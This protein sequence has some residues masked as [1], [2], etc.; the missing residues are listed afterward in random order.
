MTYIAVK[1]EVL[2]KITAYLGK[3]PY[4]EVF[5]LFK[6]LE[7]GV[8]SIQEVISALS[9]ENSEKDRERLSKQ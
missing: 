6:A 4:I 1:K 2:D 7:G 5:S 8:T 3:K 9:K